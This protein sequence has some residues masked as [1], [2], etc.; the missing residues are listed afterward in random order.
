[1]V[2]NSVAMSEENLDTAWL[3]E[4]ANDLG[5]ER[6][7]ADQIEALLS[8]AGE[9]ARRSGDRRNAPISCFLAGLRL[10]SDG[11]EPTAGAISALV[12]D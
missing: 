2:C 9:A 10:G 5:T 11:R 6:L 3:D 8:L 1:M 12:P 4:F 7:N